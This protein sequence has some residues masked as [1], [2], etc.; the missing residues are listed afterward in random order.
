MK[1]YLQDH[2]KRLQESLGALW[3]NVRNTFMYLQFVSHN[4]IT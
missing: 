2:F 3:E 1:G 4:F